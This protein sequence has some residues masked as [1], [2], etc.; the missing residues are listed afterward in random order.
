MSISFSSSIFFWK[1][2]LL[3]VSTFTVPKK[4]IIWVEKERSMKLNKFFSPL[5]EI[6]LSENCLVSQVVSQTKSFCPYLLYAVN[7][8]HVTSWIWIRIKQLEVSLDP[9]DRDHFNR[10]ATWG[11]PGW[12]FQMSSSALKSITNVYRRV[13]RMCIYVLP[14]CVLCGKTYLPMTCY[15]FQ[16]VQVS[17]EKYHL[18]FFHRQF[19]CIVKA[20][21]QKQTLQTSVGLEC[22]TEIAEEAKHCNGSIH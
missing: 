9:L 20:A 21:S 6:L 8:I 17:K 12:L 5:P 11:M 1:G 7:V 16:W 13:C 15:T 4:F 2:L 3:S 18:S 10:N 19:I 22:W 14:T